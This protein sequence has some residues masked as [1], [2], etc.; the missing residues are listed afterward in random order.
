MQRTI[1]PSAVDTHACF[2]LDVRRVADR[3]ASHEIVPGATWRDPEAIDSWIDT[4]PQD[5][6][7]V[8]YCVRGGSVSSSVVARL[9]GAGIKACFIEGGIE[10][11]K[12]AGGNVEQR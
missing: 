10:G 8:L 9:Q 5:R 11:Y 12:A 2:V 3:E 6:D 4:L 1:H 7:V